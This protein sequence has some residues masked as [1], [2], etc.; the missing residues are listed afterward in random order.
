MRTLLVTLTLLSSGYL[1]ATPY[2]ISQDLQQAFHSS[3]T[4]KIDDIIDF[5]SVKKSVSKQ[6][7]PTQKQDDGL[8]ATI[9]KKIATGAIEL[10]VDAVVTPEGLAQ[11]MEGNTKGA[12]QKNGSEI[13]EDHLD[14]NMYYANWN[15]FHIDVLSK[16]DENVVATFVLTRSGVNWVVTE[17]LIAGLES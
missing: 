2:L 17:I 16:T 13:S 15:R 5:E 7:S 12:N 3:D 6:L 9:G 8:L 14:Y 1:L 10:V 4:E 11:I